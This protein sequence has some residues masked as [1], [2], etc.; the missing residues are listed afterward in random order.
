VCSSDL[1]RLLASCGYRIAVDP[2]SASATLEIQRRWMN[3]LGQLTET[4]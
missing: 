4:A 1:V 3:R 2:D